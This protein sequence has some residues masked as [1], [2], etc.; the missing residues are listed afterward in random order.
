MYTKGTFFLTFK[1]SKCSESMNYPRS[2]DDGDILDLVF[3]LIT[4]LSCYVLLNW[5][6]HA[7]YTSTL[8]TYFFLRSVHCLYNTYRLHH[9]KTCCIVSKECVC[10]V[11]SQTVDI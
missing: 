9:I 11:N 5:T 3:P 4:S 7:L 2:G 8:N 6:L 10:R 1:Q